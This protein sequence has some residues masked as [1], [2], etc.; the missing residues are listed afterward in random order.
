[1]TPAPVVP[2]GYVGAGNAHC[3]AAPGKCGLKR[4]PRGES[5]G[6][7]CSIPGR[8]DFRAN[9]RVGPPTDPSTDRSPGP[10]AAYPG[11]A[12]SWANFRLNGH[13]SWEICRLTRFQVPLATGSRT[14]RGAAG[15]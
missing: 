1:M 12:A 8:P 9:P 15:F 14:L 11:S 7:G 3:E 4:S 13:T 6:G 5:S 2:K 10:R